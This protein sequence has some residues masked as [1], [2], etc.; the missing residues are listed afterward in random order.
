MI[1]IGRLVLLKQVAA[2]KMA[3]SQVEKHWFP[4]F[5]ASPTR[6]QLCSKEFAKL[7][8]KFHLFHY[9]E[10]SQLFWHH[11]PV[12]NFVLQSSP[13]FR[14]SGFP[15]IHEIEKVSSMRLYCQ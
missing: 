12:I 11:P 9:L 6:H 5:L 2:V 14:K 3:L 15:P 7:L 1:I 10:R 8:K 4:P 13:N